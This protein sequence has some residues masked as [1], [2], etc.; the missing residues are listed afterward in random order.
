VGYVCQ[1]VDLHGVRTEAAVRRLLITVVLA[2]GLAAAGCSDLPVIATP[3]PTAT[4]AAGSAPPAQVAGAKAELARLRVAQPVPGGYQ[5]TRDFGPAWSIDFDRNGCG[6]RD[7]VLRRDLRDVRLRGRCTVIAGTLTDPYT[8]R[9]VVFRKAHA[10]EVQIDHVFPL[11]AAWS[12]GARDWSR[13]QRERFANDPLN[14]LAT[15]ADAN[16]AKGDGTPSEWLPTPAYRCAYAVRWVQVADRYRLA[17]S[18]ADRSTLDR[19]LR[20]CSVG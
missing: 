8:G 3:A 10:D 5:R 20:S 13:A 16:Q 4:G 6:T 14:L 1:R 18:P 19:L 7:D 12:L 17:V 9:M 11:A 2:A 15:S